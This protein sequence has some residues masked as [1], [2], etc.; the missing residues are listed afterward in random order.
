M[1]L[2]GRRSLLTSGIGNKTYLGVLWHGAMQGCFDEEIKFF[3]EV[4]WNFQENNFVS[5]IGVLS[6]LSVQTWQL[7]VI[8][9]V[10]TLQRVWG[11][12]NSGH[13]LLIA[14]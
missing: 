11:I 5:P 10:S 13:F 2:F 6:G 14:A 1:L 3:G 8:H 4:V 9:S 12:R 7:C